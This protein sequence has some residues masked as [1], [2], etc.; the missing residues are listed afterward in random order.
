MATSNVHKNFLN[1]G[2]IVLEIR[3]WRDRQAKRQAHH[4]ILL[5]SQAQRNEASYNTFFNFRI[6]ISL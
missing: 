6:K 2:C 5:P 1:F 3:E 4:N